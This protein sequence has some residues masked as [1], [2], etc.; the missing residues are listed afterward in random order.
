MK[1]ARDSWKS[2]ARSRT[3]SGLALTCRYYT[4]TGCLLISYANNMPKISTRISDEVEPAG[5]RSLKEF[6]SDSLP[7]VRIQSYILSISVLVICV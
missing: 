3:S 6:G 2:K 4:H 7:T 5:L 1:S